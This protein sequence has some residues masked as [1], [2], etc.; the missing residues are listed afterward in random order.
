MKILTLNNN[1]NNNT[2]FFVKTL[3]FCFLNM[4]IIYAYLN[5]RIQEIKLL[6]NF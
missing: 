2:P 4:Y 1:N 3:Y 5:Y 6:Q